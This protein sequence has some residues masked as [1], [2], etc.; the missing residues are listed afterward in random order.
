MLERLDEIGGPDGVATGHR[1]RVV[2]QAEPRP[3][4]AAVVLGAH[5]RFLVAGD[6]AD[7]VATALACR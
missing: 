1:V 3:V 7:L 4:L 2:G 6:P 5:E